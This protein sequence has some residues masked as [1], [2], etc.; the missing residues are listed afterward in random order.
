MAR[1]YQTFPAVAFHSDHGNDA[2]EGLLFFSNIALTFQGSDLS[3]Q[4]P[5]SQLLVTFEQV[6]E[7]RLIFRDSAQP[8]LVITT[9]DLE[10]LELNSPPALVALREEVTGN[11]ARREITRRIKQVVWFCVCCVAVVWLL[12]IASSA[13]VRAIASRVSP[14]TEK[15]EG[16]KFLEEL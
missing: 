15:Q 14:Q 9:S 4:I 13:M 6:D 1:A 12:M 16:D 3:F 11:L 8:E 2:L 5:V 10:V 7:G